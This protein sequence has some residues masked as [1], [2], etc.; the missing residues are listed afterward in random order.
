M[1]IKTSKRHYLNRELYPQV[2][3]EEEQ[4]DAMN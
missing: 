4:D 3:F 1:P 2:Q